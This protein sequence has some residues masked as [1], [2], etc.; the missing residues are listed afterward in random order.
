MKS[1]VIIFRDGRYAYSHGENEAQAKSAWL[2]MWEDAIFRVAPGSEFKEAPA[3]TG[4][5]ADPKP[6]VA[7]PT[8]MVSI[9]PLDFEL[10]THG[11][12]TTKHPNGT[13]EFDGVRYW[14]D[15]YV[16]RKQ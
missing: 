1:W 2:A 3:F 7:M 9:H 10:M 16:A 8:P 12:A 11:L 5:I 15:E 14:L 13:I 6:P 4:L